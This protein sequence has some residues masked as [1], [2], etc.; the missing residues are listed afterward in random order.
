MSR[1][2][3][4][5]AEL[6]ARRARGRYWTSVSALPCRWLG[7][8]CCFC[9]VWCWGEGAVPLCHPAHYA[10][11]GFASRAG[12]GKA[13]FVLCLYCVVSFCIMQA[14]SSRCECPEGRDFVPL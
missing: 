8:G 5:Q 7:Y 1:R 12:L 14:S 13:A 4:G 2:L 9:A 3:G 6:E 11:S 10:L